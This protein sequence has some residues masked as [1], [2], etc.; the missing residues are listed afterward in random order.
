MNRSKLGV[1]LIVALTLLGTNL[2]SAE[3]LEEAF[4]NGKMSGDIRAYYFDRDNGTSHENILATGVMLNYVTDSYNGLKAGF[5][6]QSSQTPFADAA[7]KAMFTS[8]MWA[9]G[10]QLSEAYVA[11]TL[12]KIE[13]KVGRMYLSTPLIAGSGSRLIREAFEGLSL[14]NT[15]LS[16]TTLGAVYID[17]F[18]ARTNRAGDIGEFVQYGDGMYSLY[19]INK[20]IAGLTLTAAWA[21]N[22][23]RQN[24]PRLGITQET[25]LDI[26]YTEVFYAN[27]IGALGYS[28]SGQYWLNKYSSVGLGQDDTI[29]GYALKLGGSYADVSGYVAYSQISNDN[30]PGTTGYNYLSHGAGNGS[31]IIYTNALISSYNYDPNMKAYAAGLEYAIMPAMTVGSIYAYTDT[32]TD[33]ARAIKNE[34]VSYAGFYSSYSFSGTLKGLSLIAQYE[35]LGEDKDGNEFRF[36]GS[37]KF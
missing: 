35:A 4:K 9:Q 7:S 32:D 15:N 19:A 11:Y 17:K 8:D 21:K 23:D 24:V 16:N 26:Y 5:T 22:K 28:V 3:T 1:S 2:S 27:K 25:D 13:A 18:Q 36:K 37:Y 10:A 12:G 34:K 6:F 14:V 20:S 31:D 29:D 30:V 33:A